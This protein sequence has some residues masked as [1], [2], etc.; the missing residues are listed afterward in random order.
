MVVADLGGGSGGVGM[1][2]R[3]HQPQRECIHWPAELGSQ[4]NVWFRAVLS[5]GA[6]I[7][8]T[9][10][11]FSSAF[12]SSD[13]VLALFPT[14]APGRSRHHPP[15]PGTPAEQNVSFLTPELTLTA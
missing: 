12:S 1:G 15:Y 14:A 10:P 11:G 8:P 4:G 9:G 7:T 6:Q 13:T 5:Q 2:R 3:E